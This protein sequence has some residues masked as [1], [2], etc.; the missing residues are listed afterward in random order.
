MQRIPVKLSAPERRAVGRLRSRGEHLVREVNR[1]HILAAL[2]AGLTDAQIAA[3]LGVS[4][5]VIWR[6]RSAFQEKGLDY[7]LHDIARSG[8]PPSYTTADE[9]A[10]TALAGSPAPPGRKRWTVE[11]LTQAAGEQTPKVR[12][13]SRETVRRWLK[14]TS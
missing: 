14:K 7:A 10:I 12:K 8:A 1:A 6:T 4:R 2:D 5:M 3:V 11:L 9:A 13:P